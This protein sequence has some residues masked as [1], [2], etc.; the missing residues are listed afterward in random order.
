MYAIELVL[1]DL[2]EC[3]IVDPSRTQWGS[4]RSVVAV[5]IVVVA[6]VVIVVSSGVV[7]VAEGVNGVAVRQK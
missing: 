5:V 1:T 3:G 4:V 7:V 6:V 2:L